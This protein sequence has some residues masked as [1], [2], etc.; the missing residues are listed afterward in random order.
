MNE[1]LEGTYLPFT[2]E[3]LLNHFAKVKYR[4]ECV[5]NERHLSYY[6]NSIQRY[7][8]YLADTQDMKGRPLSEMK[9]PRQIEK[10]ERFWVASC[11]MTMFYH[12]RR[13]QMLQKLFTEA[14]GADPP[15]AG[16]NS[17]QE[18]LEGDLEIFFETT[19]PSPPS[20][21]TWLGQNL[22]ERQ[23]IPYVLHG[24]HGKP[25][26]EG[27]THVDALLINP[28]NG[29][30]VIVEAKVLSDISYQIT[31]DAAR[32]Q[33]ART[34]DVMLEENNHLCEPLC[35]RDPERTLFLLLTPEM[36]KINPSRRLYGCKFND[37]KKN[38]ESLAVELPHRKNLNW[39]MIRRKLGWLTWEDFH[40]TN[41]D[42]CPWLSK[43]ERV[44][45]E[46]VPLTTEY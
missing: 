30:A 19:L 8:R 31:Y 45:R 29:F 10:D 23:F 6:K 28:S 3:Q 1:V 37:Y 16:L 25:H 33:M 46:E 13:L 21:K 27:P 41:R 11:M 38:Q 5:R 32:N 2:E 34:I 9:Y 35:R 40:R 26:L 22:N 44:G 12:E 36:F 14:F 39:L 18:C 7:H 20:Y 43:K 17:W 42:C 15:L 24:A 4:K